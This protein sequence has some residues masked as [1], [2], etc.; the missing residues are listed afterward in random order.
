MANHR[1]AAR[2]TRE[3]GP[4]FLVRRLLWRVL[5][6]VI[7]GFRSQ[8]RVAVCYWI[9]VC[10]VGCLIGMSGAAAAQ[11]ASAANGASG[12]I[13]SDNDALEQAPADKYPTGVWRV[14]YA[15]GNDAPQL[16]YTPQHGT[17]AANRMRND[18]GACID[19][20]SGNSWKAKFPD[21]GKIDIREFGAVANDQ[22]PADAAVAAA[23]AYAESVHGC[24]YIP[25]SHRGFLFRSPIK[26]RLD[27][28]LIGSRIRGW[29]VGQPSMTFPASNLHFVADTDGIET[30]AHGSGPYNCY[31]AN[32]SLMGHAAQS[33]VA[34]HTAGLNLSG[35]LDCKIENVFIANFV[36]CREIR[37]P[38]GRTVLRDIWCNDQQA[39]PNLV[40]D[41]PYACTEIDLG[42]AYAPGD[43]QATGDVCREQ[44]WTSATLTQGDGSKTWFDIAKPP[45]GIPLWRADGIKVR[46]GPP[47]RLANG[48]V[49]YAAPLKR[50]GMGGEGDYTLWDISATGG[51]GAGGT[52]L[53]CTHTTARLTSGNAMIAVPSTAGYRAGANILA[54]ADHGL[55]LADKVARIV[56]HT[57]LVLTKPPYVT[58]VVALTLTQENIVH[59]GQGGT[60]IEVRFVTPPHGRSDIDIHWIDPTGYA[61]YDITGAGDY[62]FIRPLM[63]GGYDVALKH[64][65]ARDGGVTFEPTYVELLNQCI[66]IGRETYGDVTIFHRII[67]PPIPDCPGYVDPQAGPT[68]T[69][70]NNV[71][72][73]YNG[74]SF[75]I[76][77][78]PSSPAAPPRSR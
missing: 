17:C 10:L 13:I 68:I 33:T 67:N 61:A 76:T 36:I 16:F 60:K 71:Y 46:V 18:G 12:M 53:F 32:L 30:P 73:L 69:A 4:V 26:I 59:D 75:G 1:K 57:H 15:R 77:A 6:T 43:T 38:W 54:V 40:N 34:T 24:V 9:I 45:G 52:Q 56:D 7:S 48:Q 74:A 63:V 35:L 72:H 22:A 29:A 47:T 8:S 11:Q 44:A 23:L 2:R 64:T 37:G 5:Q 65:G 3:K 19:A 58:G 70:Y 78:S 21:P 50:C 25:D 14:D 31:I 49:V 39:Y 20:R 42:T 55:P 51:E 41:F 28:C 27:T 62:W 66:D